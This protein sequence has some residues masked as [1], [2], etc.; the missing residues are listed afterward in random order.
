MALSLKPSDMFHATV[1][2]FP[3]GKEAIVLA[4]PVTADRDSGQ[5][6]FTVDLTSGVARRWKTA[7]DESK[8]ETGCVTHDGKMVLLS[9]AARNTRRIV[10]LPRSGNSAGRTL[11]TVTSRPWGLSAGPEGDIYTD[12]WERTAEVVSFPAAGGH[13]EKIASFP[14]VP[15]LHP[16]AILPGGRVAVPVTVGGYDRLMAVQPGEAATPLVT[17]TEESAGP[18]AALGDTEVAFLIGPEPR[19]TIG[20]AA[21]ATGRVARRIALNKGSITALAAA[22]DGRTL[23]SAAGG[24]VWA[25]PSAGGDAH[26]IRAG[27]VVAVD[28]DGRT[29]TITSTEGSRV[30]LFRVPLDGGAEQEIVPAAGIPVA[31]SYSSSP[32]AVGPEGRL[33]VPLA[34]PDTWF[35]PPGIIDRGGHVTRVPL[36]F[37]SDFHSIAWTSDG[38]LAALALNV[39]SRIWRFRREK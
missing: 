21:L 22:R 10:A 32:D 14:F 17:T 19:Q 2:A 8:V 6:L 36:D 23:Y 24:M 7:L 9:V 3:D 15:A 1:M 13:A 34:P 37:M 11:V 39:R 4:Q 27:Q 18:A 33:A 30:R 31:Y 38:R 25:I 26:P 29:L 12:L 16:I 28:P 35:W 20:V 5:H